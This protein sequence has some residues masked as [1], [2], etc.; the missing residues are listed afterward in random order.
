MI[1]LPLTICLELCPFLDSWDLANFAKSCKLIYGLLKTHHLPRLTYLYA[2]PALNPPSPCPPNKATLLIKKPLFSPVSLLNPMSISS[3]YM[4][5][6]TITAAQVLEI[7]IAFPN[8]R[9]FYLRNT[10]KLDLET[11][12]SLLDQALGQGLLREKGLALEAFHPSRTTAPLRLSNVFVLDDL[13]RLLSK[14]SSKLVQ[15]DVTLCMTCGLICGHLHCISFSPKLSC[16]NCGNSYNWSCKLCCKR[17]ACPRC[18]RLICQRCRVFRRT[19]ALS[20][21]SLSCWRC[22]NKGYE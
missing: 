21:L 18:A 20:K 22:D 13:R 10:L 11:L 5:G 4:D 9:V 19:P 15:L 17:L 14:L 1:P 16:Y 8:L 2:S 7:L 6:S 12:T 3:A